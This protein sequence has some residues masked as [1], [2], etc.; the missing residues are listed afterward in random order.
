MIMHTRED[1]ISI[2]IVTM[3]IV[4][5]EVSGNVSVVSTSER[6]ANREALLTMAVQ[7]LTLVA[8]LTAVVE[9]EGINRTGIFDT[10]PVPST[11]KAEGTKSF[12]F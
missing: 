4:M 10:F 3:G 11:E 6:T 8:P 2:L 7:A 12:S 5:K 9:E 1:Y